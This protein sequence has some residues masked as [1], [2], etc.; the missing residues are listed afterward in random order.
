[1]SGQS[2]TEPKQNFG[3]R[4]GK[5]LILGNDVQEQDHM[6]A[7]AKAIASAQRLRILKYLGTDPANM[8]Q[9]SKDLDIP[10]STALQHLK[11]L[12]SAHL[13][14]S[15]TTPGLRG[16]QRIYTRICDAIVMQMPADEPH[17]KVQEVS[18][19][20]PVGA[21]VKH[22]VTPTCGLA[23]NEQP[24]GLNDDPISFFEPNK[25]NAQ[26]VWFSEGYVEYHFPNRFYQKSAARNLRLSV[27]LCSEAAPAKNIWPSDIYME[28]NGVRI[29]TWTS[30]GDFNDRRGRLNPSWWDDGGTQYGLLKVWQVNE[31]AS[32]IDGEQL[33][34]VIISDL[35]IEKEPFIAIRL[36]VDPEAIHVGGINIFGHGFGNH[37]QDII[38]QMF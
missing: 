8:S 27:E 26:L 33:S 31:E 7:V 36:G 3:Q 20:M 32:Y 2:E 35:K 19:H 12:E 13:V 30:P 10:I 15:R 18:I 17:Q 23:G 6:I 34:N 22:Q 11:V 21:Y 9:L 4:R 37:A 5:T 38:L 25:V 29:G 1:M 14:K 24:I 28:I 16:Q